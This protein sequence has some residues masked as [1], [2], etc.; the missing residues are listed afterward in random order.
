ME[1]TTSVFSMKNKKNDNNR[2][3][4]IILTKR[5]AWN[6]S[7]LWNL[8]GVTLELEFPF[9]ICSLSDICQVHLEPNKSFKTTFRYVTFKVL[10]E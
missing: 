2:D 3:L 4:Y 5:L 10:K 9:Q 1:R 6:L 8:V 7:Y